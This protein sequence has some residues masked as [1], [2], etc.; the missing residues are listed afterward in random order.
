MTLPLPDR[1]AA[2]RLPDPPDA[3][4]ELQ[5]Y[6]LM[7]DSIREYA[8]FMTDPAGIVNR[9]NVGAERILGWSEAQILGRPA[10]VVYTPEDRERGVHVDEMEETCREGSA[11]DERWHVRR[12]GSRFFAWGRLMVVRDDHGRHVGFVKVL[13]DMTAEKEAQAERDRL[14]A[15]SRDTA[16][17]LQQWFDHAPGFVALL[18]GPDHVF[19]LAN[20]A[21][22]RLV[23]H[24]DIL[25]RPAFEALPEIRGQGFETMLDDVYRSGR[26]FEGRGLRVAVQRTPGAPMTEAFVDLIY[27]PVRDES[28]AVVGIFVQG[29]EVTAQHR[30]LAALRQSEAQFRLMADAVPQIVWITD[31][32]GRTEFFNRQWT[33]YTGE[34]YEP[35]TAAEVAAGYV[36]P[37]DVEATMAAFDRARATGGVFEIEHRI[38][39]AGGEYRWFLVRAEPHRDERSGRIVRWFGVSIDIHDRR[40]AE[41][42]LRESEQRFRLIAEG[43]LAR[44]FVWDLSTGL[45]TLPSPANLVF[46]FGDEPVHA[47]RVFEKVHPDDVA[48]VR[49]DIE[50]AF[51]PRGDGQMRASYRVVRS[52]GSVRWVASSGQVEFEAQRDGERRPVRAFGVIW[53]V[54]EQ[55]LLLES[56]QEADR[57]K[58]EFLAM[59]AHELRNP[60]APMRNAIRVLEHEPLGERG[61]HA[62]GMSLRQVRHLTRLV[63]DLLEVSRVSR[64][65]I[66]LRPEPVMV[67]HVVHGAADAVASAF[68]DRGQRLEFE[69]PG[70]PLQMRADPVRLTQIVENLLTNACKY[71]DPG[72]EVVVRVREEGDEAIA[73]EVRDTGIGIAADHLPRIFTL[74]A[75]VE[76]AIDRSRGGLGIGLALVRRLVELHGGTI[77]AHSDG[78]GRGSTFT[79]RLPRSAP[80]IDPRSLAAAKPGAATTPRR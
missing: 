24:R 9:W 38:R 73:I 48:A 76:T 68:E 49:A 64:G 19:E 62:L 80:A 14:L 27:E 58:D 13:R 35:A 46:E 8:V 41:E 22:C 21:Y 66:E 15:A 16:R 74:F 40:R 3:A 12:D 67:Q 7:L 77:S 23:G 52:D 44:Q 11:A 47:D 26:R 30:A 75:Q 33:R 37:D 45:V 43:V 55:R 10:A 53:D 59:L 17:T 36:H 70:R 72:G 61:R 63:D 18:K 4:A 31:P 2:D 56:L 50:S 25:G 6:R 29:H 78:P 5:Q 42:A 79:V 71:T 20:E 60:L 54:T 57:R 34:P 69:M 39:S 51:D 32:D 28:G 1:G 65:L